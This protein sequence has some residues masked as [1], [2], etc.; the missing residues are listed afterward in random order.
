[1][2]R[3]STASTIVSGWP[4]TAPDT[5]IRSSS[6]LVSAASAP[7]SAEGR[8]RAAGRSK[9]RAA[10]RGPAPGSSARSGSCSW[11]AAAPTRRSSSSRMLRSTTPP[12]A[13][14]TE[15]AASWASVRRRSSQ[16]RR[17][18]ISEG[19]KNSAWVSRIAATVSQ[20]SRIARRW[21]GAGGS[22]ALAGSP[23]S[24][25]RAAGNAARRPAAA[26]SWRARAAAAARRESA[27]RP[28]SASR[29][30]R[31]RRRGRRR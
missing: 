7:D 11:I 17:S 8:I 18:R 28:G 22:R 16:S 27:A 25:T 24:I 23:A 21:R 9:S 3:C 29:R 26:R 14:L 20:A 4:G 2:A 1:M 13:S 30:T 15:R 31:A 6:L 5:A 19:T 12:G 10:C